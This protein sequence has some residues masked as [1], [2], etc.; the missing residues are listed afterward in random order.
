[1]FTRILTELERK[2]AK[3]YIKADG[4]KVTNI[5]VMIMRYKRDKRQIL[6]DLK[7]LDQ[8]LATYEKT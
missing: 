5:R 4:A 6:D 2:E 7:L 1:M 3:A 8:L